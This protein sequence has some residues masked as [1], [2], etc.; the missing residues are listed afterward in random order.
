MQWIC[1]AHPQQYGWQHPT[2]EGSALS[3][4]DN[5]PAFWGKF[6]QEADKVTYTGFAVD[7]GAV[8]AQGSHTDSE[9]TGD[10]P[11]SKPTAEIPGN[12]LLTRSQRT[13]R[14]VSG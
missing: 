7:I 13:L 10:L 12:L 5:H 1:Y 4:P 6:L 9:Q 3:D 14:T 11:R 2:H 8:L